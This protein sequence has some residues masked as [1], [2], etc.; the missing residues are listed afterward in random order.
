MGPITEEQFIAFGHAVVQPGYDYYQNIYNRVDGELFNIKQAYLGASVFD[1]LKLKEMNFDTALL[2]IDNLAHFHFPEFTTAFLKEMKAELPRVLEHAHA[3]FDWSRVPGAAEYDARLA[4]KHQAIGAGGGGSS[5]LAACSSSSS[6]S[7]VASSSIDVPE[8]DVV[9]TAAR[10]A[11]LEVNI[12]RWENDP[13]ERARRIWEWWVTRIKDA[14][15][16]RTWPF[17][18]RLV[19]LVQPSN[20]FVERAFS[21]IKLILEQTGVSSLEENI[22]ARVLVRC[23]SKAV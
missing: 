20:A 11:S 21:Q 16:F 9:D 4:R 22:E 3:D 14:A 1:P 18:L 5:S 23:N 19:V 12:D 2:L 6:S 10:T 15:F 7:S 13:A 8:E 17:A